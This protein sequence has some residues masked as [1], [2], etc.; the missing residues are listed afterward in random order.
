MEWISGNIFIRPMK[1]EKAG[2]QVEGHTHNFDHTT[3]LFTGAVHVIATLPNGAVV[4]RDFEAPSH[5]LVRKDVKHQIIAT[6]DKTE[7]WC[8]YAHRNAQGDVVQ[9]FDGWGDSYK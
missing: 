5:F 8:I 4:E 2:E 9:E 1:F 6:K 7:A 3:V